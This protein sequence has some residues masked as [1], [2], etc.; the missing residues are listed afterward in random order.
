MANVSRDEIERLEHIGKHLQIAYA[1]VVVS[2]AALNHQRAE[3]DDEI[4][5]VLRHCVAPRL[6]EQIERIDDIVARL[7]TGSSAA[8]NPPETR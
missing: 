1:G 4:A 3:Q 8:E 7:R 5:T 2:A 6:F